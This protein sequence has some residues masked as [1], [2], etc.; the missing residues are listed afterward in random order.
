M[1]P[2]REWWRTHE[3]YGKFNPNHDAR[4]RFDV[5]NSGH[6]AEV[7]QPTFNTVMVHQ[8]HGATER[9]SGGSR[10]WRNNNS[11]NIRYGNFAVAQGAIGEAGGFAVFP[12]QEAGQAAQEALLRSP[13]YAHLSVN[14]AIAKRSPPSENNT[15]SLKNTIKRLSGL[16]GDERIGSLTSDQMRHFTA[17]IQRTEGWRE[18]TIT[19]GS[20]PPKHSR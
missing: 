3:W 13:A 2:R 12:N 18:G 10:S 20:E 15:Q 4:G 6:A 17:A 5:G 14:D 11:G 7:T 1:H 8:P 9:R 16:N 19:Y